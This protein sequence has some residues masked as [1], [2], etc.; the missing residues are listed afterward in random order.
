MPIDGAGPHAEGAA[1]SSSDDPAMEI[2]E[3][4]VC[5]ESD[6]APMFSKVCACSGSIRHVHPECLRQWILLRPGDSLACEICH[7]PYR[8]TQERKFT[9]S[10]RTLCSRESWTSYFELVGVAVMI[11]CLMITLWQLHSSAPPDNEPD[12]LT[13]Y[14]VMAVLGAVLLVASLATLKKI[15]LRWHQANSAITLATSSEVDAERPAAA[16]EGAVPPFIAQT[17]QFA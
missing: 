7:A 6:G 2:P 8:V 11:S 12:G 17:S 4:R 1:S 9:C 15:V 14:A 5:K 16:G 10:M 3:C 13:N